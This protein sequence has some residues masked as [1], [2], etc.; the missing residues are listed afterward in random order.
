MTKIIVTNQTLYS[1]SELANSNQLPQLQVHFIGLGGAGANV[2][3]YIYAN[4]KEHNAKYTMITHPI[5]E[6]LPQDIQFID[7]PFENYLKF[8]NLESK[9][10][11]MNLFKKNEY[12]VLFS[13]LGS[14]TG[15]YLTEKLTLHLF[16]HRKTFLTVCSLPFH[17]EGRK[18]A[19]T[20]HDTIKKLNPIDSFKYFELET[21][22]EICKN[23]SIGETFEI[24]NAQLYTVY[25][26]SRLLKNSPS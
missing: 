9:N 10:S 13:G 16:Q 5:R 17:F 7:A 15:T 26:N 1:K 3:D 23:R 4:K 22:H 12:F 8:G 11:I 18:P 14:H 6:N 25:T 24:A 2:V 20:A 21:L 19:K